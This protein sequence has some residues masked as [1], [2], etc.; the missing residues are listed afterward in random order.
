MNKDLEH[1]VVVCSISKPELII[2]DSWDKM[3]L[4]AYVVEAELV[5]A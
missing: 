3:H 4:P 5:S 1:L 2:Q